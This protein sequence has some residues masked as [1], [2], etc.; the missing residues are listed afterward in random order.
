MFVILQNC[1][2]FYRRTIFQRLLAGEAGMKGRLVFGLDSPTQNVRVFNSIEEIPPFDGVERDQYVMVKNRWL[3]W[4]WVWQSGLLREVFRRDVRVVVSQGDPYNLSSILALVLIRLFTRKRVLLWTIA[5]MERP[6]GIK[7]IIKR[8]L[9]QLPHGMLLYGH[10]GR[11]CLIEDFGHNPDRLY[12]IFNSL[13]QIRQIEL[14]NAL[15][16]KDVIEERKRIF[17]STHEDPV[18]FHI[19]RLN[20]DKK[21][22]MLL[23]AAAVLLHDG[24]PI[25]VLLVGDGNAVDEL[26]RQADALAISDRVRFYGKCYDEE[27]TARLIS[28]ADV[29]VAPSDLGLM[30]MHS[31]IYGTPVITHD[32]PEDQAP[33]SE[34]IIPGKTGDLFEYDNVEA[35]TLTIRNWIETERD[36]EEIQRNCYE[37]IQQYYNPENQIKVFRAALEGVPASRVSR[38][39]SRYAL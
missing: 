27:K 39:G 5:I 36:R 34:A 15:D 21:L 18:V 22:H 38:G 30:A 37:V 19:G 13:D 11:K 9:W 6:R 17:E 3:R 8:L 32:N 12:V 29:G 1:F 10:W 2:A 23:E 20:H 33:E 25:N 28:C 35:L 7:G 16:G 31:L 26:R 4:P 14:R 24:Q